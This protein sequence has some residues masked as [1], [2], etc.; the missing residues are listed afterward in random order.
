MSVTLASTLASAGVGIV[1]IAGCS[2]TGDGPKPA[3]PITPMQSGDRS[4][5]GFGSNGGATGGAGKGSKGGDGNATPV[6]GPGGDGGAGGTG[7]TV[8]AFGASSNANSTPAGGAGSEAFTSMPPSPADQAAGRDPVIATI[9]KGAVQI[10]LSQVQKPLLEMYGL[11]M[12]LNVVQLEMARTEARQ[13][14]YVLTKADLDYERQWTLSKMFAQAKPEDYPQLFD[15]YLAQERLT[16]EQFDLVLET[17]AYLRKLAGPAVESAMTDDALRKSFAAQYGEKVKV[18]HIALANP[19]EAIAVKARLAR[20]EDFATLAKQLSRNG[21]TGANG[22]DLPA[23]TLNTPGL[24][25]AFKDVAFGLKEGEVSE[26]VAAE[27]SYHLI[28]LEKRIPVKAV[29]FE[30][31][32]ESLR[33]QMRDAVLQKAVA[34]ARQLLAAQALV[35]LKITEPTL[36]AEWQK[37]LDERD[38]LLKEK[39]PG[40]ASTTGPATAPATPP[41]STTAPATQ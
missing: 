36:A 37:K 9:G 13:K 18:R 10:R 14:G 19:Q 40:P 21:E 33:D 27:G 1:G 8:A 12:L 39:Q 30:D 28:K 34:E 32:K 25:Q 31:V 26:P 6:G 38:R 5:G 17:N 15:R 22:G 2:A 4:A 29:K 16:A 35:T 7:G 23:F 11:N 24:P 20:G 3:P 41:A